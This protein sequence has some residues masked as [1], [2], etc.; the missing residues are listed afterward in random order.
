MLNTI[1]HHWGVLP[2]GAGMSCPGIQVGLSERCTVRKFEEGMRDI[3][4][5]REETITVTWARDDR[6]FGPRTNS[7]Y[8]TGWLYC[9]NE[10]MYG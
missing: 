6:W 2:T 9:L 1:R 4:E 10:I 8:R 7:A 5:A 3:R